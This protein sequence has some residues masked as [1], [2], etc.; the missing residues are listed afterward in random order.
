[1][2]R[3]ELSPG[4]PVPRLRFRGPNLHLP[5][6]LI[7]LGWAGYRTTVAV[8]WL[9]LHPRAA[10]ALAGLVVAWAV[11]L[12]WG[13]APYGWTM[14]AATVVLGTW[15]AR[16]PGSF[17]RQVTT[18]LR[19][20]WRWLAVYRRD[21]QPAMVTSG[22]SL[23]QNLGA[24][25]PR[26]RRVRAEPARDV[27]RVRMLPGQT[28][29]QWQAAGPRLAA[30]FGVR[31]VRVRRVR[32]V[33]GRPLDLDVLCLRRSLPVADTAPDNI[34]VTKPAPVEDTQPATPPRGAFPRAPRRAS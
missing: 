32:R 21:W 17:G 3:R 34:D 18:R 16:W 30:T 25:L 11:W 13:W 7:A 29:E 19:S 31:A 20:R 27:L 22:L 28:V 8:V 5:L 2:L 4:R 6:W 10:L 14:A 26:L 33:P 12:R 1:M 15:W 23:A 24:S 9:V